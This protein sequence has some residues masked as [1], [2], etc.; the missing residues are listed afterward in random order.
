MRKAEAA[1]ADSTRLAEIARLE[2]EEAIKKAEAALPRKI[3]YSTEFLLVIILIF[4]GAVTSS[5]LFSVALTYW[6]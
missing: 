5:V 3:V 1:G 2:A 4:L 6:R